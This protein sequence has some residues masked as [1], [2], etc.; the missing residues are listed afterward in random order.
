M[1]NPEIFVF[2]TIHFHSAFYSGYLQTLSFEIFHEETAI[3]R[4]STYKG[5]R[6]TWAI[7]I[8]NFFDLLLVFSN[9]NCVNMLQTLILEKGSI[10]RE[11]N[12]DLTKQ[13]NFYFVWGEQNKIKH[14]T[15][16]VLLLGKSCFWTTFLGTLCDGAIFFNKIHA[17][18]N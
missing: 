15:S 7:S 13:D 4:S 1:V 2:Q 3:M 6:L 12:I 5:I 8:F 17:F 16:W 9:P 18:Y 14:G 11:D 10:P